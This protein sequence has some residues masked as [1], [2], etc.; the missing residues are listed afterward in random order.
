VTHVQG[1]ED[2]AMLSDDEALL[3][4]GA[5]KQLAELALQLHNPK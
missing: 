2:G 5:G 1:K 3:A 4:H